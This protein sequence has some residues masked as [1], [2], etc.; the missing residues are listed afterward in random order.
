MRYAIIDLDI[1]HALLADYSEFKTQ[2]EAKQCEYDFNAIRLSEEETMAKFKEIWEN[3]K[4]AGMDCTPI[5]KNYEQDDY[6]EMDDYFTE[7]KEQL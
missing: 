3:G 2:D 4:E 6:D 7:L 5:G 1:Y